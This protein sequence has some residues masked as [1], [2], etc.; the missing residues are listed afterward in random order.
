E[1][2]RVPCSQGCSGRRP[3]RTAG[4]AGGRVL[5]TPVLHERAALADPQRAHR[6]VIKV[7]SSSLTDKD[8]HLDVVKLTRLVD[9]LARRIEAGSQI[10]LVSSV[11]IASALTV[12]GLPGRPKDLALAQAAASVGQGLLMAHYTRAFGTHKRHVGQ[13]L[14]TVEDVIRRSHYGNAQQALERLL[15]LGVVPIVNENDAV[16]THEIRF[17]DNDRLA[18]LVAHLTHADALLL[19]TDVDALYDG[20]PSRPGTQRVP[21]VWTPEDL[22]GLEITEPRSRLGTGGMVTTVEAARIATGAGSGCPGVGRRRIWTAWGS[23]NRAA[24]W[25]PAAWSP[26]SRRPVSPPAP[27]SRWCSPAPPMPPPP[28]PVKKWAPGSPP[29]AAGSVAAACGLRTPPIPA[30]PSTSTTARSGR[31]P[32]ARSPSWP[33]GSPAPMAISRVATRSN[34][35]AGTA[36]WWRAGSS[37]TPPRNSPDASGAPRSSYAPG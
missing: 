20:P 25:A 15:D 29:P 10:T 35:P 26:R 33:P 22:A 17:G 3:R 28:W 16:A 7:G 21:A 19:L 2:C 37:P 32:R 24:G 27:G 13:V 23:T 11:A 5:V 1:A 30:A 36:P 18:A 12:L 4:R 6:L 14:L 34:W 8:G 9:V 31:P